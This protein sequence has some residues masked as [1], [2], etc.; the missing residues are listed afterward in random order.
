MD[1]R[2]FLRIMGAAG[3]AL[4]LPSFPALAESRGEVSAI[5][6]LMFHKVDDNPR[7]PESISSE[8]LAALLAEL[9]RIGFHPVNM[10][11]ILDNQVDRVVPKGLKPV[12]ITADDAHRSVVFSRL[13][14]T[15][16]ELPNAR[17]LLEILQD[18]LK[19]FGREP[20]ATIF[21]SRVEDDRITNQQG[22]YFGNYM[23][24]S[25]VLQTLEAMPGLEIGYH[26]V[27]HTR[28]LNMD[29]S[30]V[31]ELIE[32]QIADFKTLGIVDQ[33]VPV[34]AYPYG[35]RPAS[36]GIAELR[37][38][39]FKGAVLAFPGVR[40]ARYDTL[41]TCNYNGTLLTDPFLIPRV[42]IGSHIYAPNNSAQK[43]SYVA[44]DPLDD[45]RKD[46]LEALPNIY[47]SSGL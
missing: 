20:R 8:Q 5:P 1:R 16:G 34:L 46:V 13:S 47:R 21:V 44:I 28:M 42:S 29:A 32:E 35:V 23:P 45:F 39:G 33:V 6:I 17:S 36:E 38:M 2:T 40:E 27:S 37:R 30:Q 19:P 4:V 25:V 12:G 22:G 14:R 31:R 11:D 7:D 3:L 9:W 15:D 10:S 43:G 18:S 41:P 24:L 26:T